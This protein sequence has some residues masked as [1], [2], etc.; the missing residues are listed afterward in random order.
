M[1]SRKLT[2][3]DLLK[4]GGALTAGAVLAACAQPAPAPQPTQA[5]AAKAEPTKAP[6]APAPAAKQKVELWTGFGQGR[7]ADAMNGAVKRFNDKSDKFVVEHIVVPWGEIMNKVIQ[8]T[9][10]KN[11]PDV[12]RGWAWIV[13]DHAPIGGLTDLTPF[14]NADASFKPDDYWPATLEQM[15]YQGKIY[16]ISISTMIWFLYYNKDRMKEKGVDTEKTP[17]DLEGWEEVGHK[18]YELDGKKV[19]KVGFVPWIPWYNLFGWGATRGAEV[20]DPNTQKCIANDAKNKPIFVALFNWHKGYA[21]KY[22][23]EELQ[24][25]ITTYSGNTF[26]R[27][28][29]EGAWY[30]GKLGIWALE[31]WLYNDFKEYGP[32]VSFG[33]TKM[34]S[35]KGVKGKPG[36]LTANMYLVPANSKNP[37]GGYAFG[38]FMGSD[39]WVAV[40]KCVPDAVLPSRRSTATQPEVLSGLPWAKMVI[41]EIVPYV[42]PLPS[43]PAVSGYQGR[44]NTAV[45]NVLT[46]NADPAKEL[47]QAVE[48]AQ[49]DVD[50]LLKKS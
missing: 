34:P 44:L 29:P 28:T 15:K 8:S 50:K 38:H 10:A 16:A 24:A 37:A 3:R 39:P 42:M 40:N 43:M 26:G 13:G 47:D 31:T 14:A 20:W 5:P 18:L 49:K 2:R 19:N 35:P 33:V 9:A 46:Q 4:L 11:P 1:D 32:K 48:L 22:G 27:N 17:T 30:T 25:F 45:T 6:A 12:Y 41:D 36:G 23:Y 21:T 7:M